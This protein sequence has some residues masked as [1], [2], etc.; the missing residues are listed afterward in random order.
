MPNHQTIDKKKIREAV[1]L[2]L[3]G[4][5]EDPDREGLVDTPDRVA[6]MYEEIF[7]QGEQ[8]PK[9]ALSKKFDEHHRELV[10][11]KVTVDSDRK[12]T[13]LNSSHYALSRMPSSA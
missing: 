4:I 5:G 11:V 9:A 10:L 13:R 8:D 12:S 7:G 3:E 2:L 1:R 6:R